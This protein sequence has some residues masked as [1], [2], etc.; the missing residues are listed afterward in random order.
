MAKE[1]KIQVPKKHYYKDYDDLTRFVSYFYQI[2]S[3]IKT[4]PKTI[5]EVG[6]GNKKSLII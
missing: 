6:V 3:L 4:N 5:L 2:D 1:F